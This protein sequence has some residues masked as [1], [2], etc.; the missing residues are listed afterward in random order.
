MICN[1]T[2]FYTNITIP[3]QHYNYYQGEDQIVEELFDARK[4]WRLPT[5]CLVS[6]CEVIIS[7][8]FNDTNDTFIE[9]PT[10]APFEIVTN[11]TSKVCPVRRADKA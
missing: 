7:N 9:P 4:F 8:G 6:N 10:K 5:A 2:N 3:D 11:K 1:D